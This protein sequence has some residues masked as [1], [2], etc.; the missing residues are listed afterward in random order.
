M[1]EEELANDGRTTFQVW[2][3]PQVPMEAFTTPVA[4]YAAGKALED[5]LA[6]YDAFQFENRVKGDYCNAGGTQFNHPVLTG[7]EW[8]DIDADEAEEFGWAAPE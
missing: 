8:H 4:S 6:A 1:T 5:V 7:G 2:W 3:C